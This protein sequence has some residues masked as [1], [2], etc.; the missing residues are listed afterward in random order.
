LSFRVL[1]VPEDPTYNGALLKPL[2]CRMLEECGKPNADVRILHNPKAD[3][4]D[5]AKT[6]LREQILDR[7]R[8]FDLLLFLPDA[9]G[10]DRS[11]DFGGL[12]TKA[13]E[14]SVQ[15]V[16][17]AAKEEVEVWLLA[18][19]LNKL[20][21]KWG[22]IR[23]DISVKE[24]I[25]IPFL[26]RYGD[27]RRAGGGRDILMKETLQNYDGLLQRCPELAELQRRMKE[28]ILSSISP[29]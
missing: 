23:A 10:V 13:R 26:N 21:K 22:E 15:L 2:I 3:G 19:H 28:V 7:Y 16:C 27:S 24:N 8:H 20:E 4:Y 25:F 9:D 18:G 14:K 6:L 11:G 5:N 29:S 12:E 1:V 17:C